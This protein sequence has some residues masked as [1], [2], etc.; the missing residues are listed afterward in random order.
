MPKPPLSPLLTQVVTS[1]L[2]KI[3]LASEKALEEIKIKSYRKKERTV[4]RR[5]GTSRRPP[6]LRQTMA[7]LRR[8][9]T[10]NPNSSTGRRVSQKKEHLMQMQI[11]LLIKSRLMVLI[12]LS[13]LR[14]S[15]D[16]ARIIKSNATD[17]KG[18]TPRPTQ[19]PRMARQKEKVKRMLMEKHKNLEKRRSQAILALKRPRIL[20]TRIQWSSRKPKNSNPNGRNTDLVI[21]GKVVAKHLLRSKPRFHPCQRNY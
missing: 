18:R 19:L 16:S 9:K 5:C 8:L 10:R 15:K 11:M 12:L 21:G 6:P 1:R 14:K 7:M 17:Q 20:F 2:R 13:S 3:M 4:H